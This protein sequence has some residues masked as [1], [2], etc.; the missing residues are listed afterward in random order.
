VRNRHGEAHARAQRRFLEDHRQR[1]AVEDRV[2]A[3]RGPELSL[4]LDRDVEQVAQ[5]VERVVGD[6]EEVLHVVASPLLGRG[7]GVIHN[8]I[9]VP[10]P[11]S[12]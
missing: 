6:V 7:E 11:A 1:L 2:V 5:L 10:I 4:Q 3:A 9:S 8:T 12:V